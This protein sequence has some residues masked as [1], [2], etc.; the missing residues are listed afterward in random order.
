MMLDS[1]DWKIL[2]L[3][4]NDAR[5]TNIE[6]SRAIGLSASPCLARVK[7]LEKSGHISRY[8]SL[9]DSLKVGL[10]L[11]VFINVTLERQVESALERFEESIKLRPEVMECYLM[12]GESD[13]LIRVVVADI[14]ILEDF[15][16]NFLSKISG[17]GN[18][19]SSFALKQ[20]KYK[21]ALPLPG[22]K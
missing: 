14:Q 19:K 11:S 15:I 18:I 13:Y 5:I 21:T 16:L 2:N 1:I 17:I 6:L 8:V 20:V 22:G 12:T 10:K 9:V 3:L 7:A 4:Q